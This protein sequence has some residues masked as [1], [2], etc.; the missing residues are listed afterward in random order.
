MCVI[1]RNA[2]YKEANNK[3]IEISQRTLIFR[4]ITV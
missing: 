2:Q 4:L 1:S 3:T